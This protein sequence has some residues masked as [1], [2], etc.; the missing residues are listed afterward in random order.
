[1]FKIMVFYSNCSNWLEHGRKF[2]DLLIV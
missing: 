2:D 1:M